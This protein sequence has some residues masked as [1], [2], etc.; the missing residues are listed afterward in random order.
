MAGDQ[1]S[2]PP[3]KRSVAAVVDRLREQ[4]LDRTLMP[5]EPIRQEEMARRLG[6]SR[7][8]LREALRVLTTEGLLTHRPHQ[9]YFVAQ[10]SVGAL[11][12]IHA[13]LEF[14]ETELIRTVR[15]PDDEELAEL[16]SIN[17]TMA[18]ADR[19]GDVAAV[20]RLN[21]ELHNRIFALS[22]QEIY[23]SEA[24]RFW[25]L[26]EPYRM[27]HV[28]STDAA[29]ATEQHE[30]LIDALAA[31]DRAL[32]LRVLGEHRRETRNGALSML[33]RM[34]SGSTPRAAG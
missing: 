1:P 12:Q 25:T 26:S 27:L 23:L 31:H 9:G 11:R 30:Q 5:G 6:I 16:R 4:I 19:A 32:C 14:L 8:P 15:W 10:L 28:T 33:S 29:I 18:H 2:I 7:V 13:L 22:S 3:S 17:A 21:R 34:E 24:E 20:N